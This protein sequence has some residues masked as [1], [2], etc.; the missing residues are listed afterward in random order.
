MKLGE[1][2]LAVLGSI[3]AIVIGASITGCIQGPKPYYVPPA[4]VTGGWFGAQVT[5]AEPGFTVP[6]RVVQ[7]AVTQ[8]TLFV[9]STDPASQDLTTSVTNSTGQAVS[10]PVK[11]SKT[12]VA[13]TMAIPEVKP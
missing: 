13:P 3:L 1:I 4:S 6:A 9:P 2:I 7:S 5:V 11:I 8:P 10:V 12:V